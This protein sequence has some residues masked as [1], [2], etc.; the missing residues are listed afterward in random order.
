MQ[1]HPTV[2][3]ITLSLDKTYLAL[4]W[5]LVIAKIIAGQISSLVVVADVIMC[6]ILGLMSG[7]LGRIGIR[8]RRLKTERGLISSGIFV[9][10]F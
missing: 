7:R 9:L 3:A 1:V 8:V 6:V 10:Y 2:R 5:I 4:I